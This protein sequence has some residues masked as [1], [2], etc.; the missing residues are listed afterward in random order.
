M[1]M[2]LLRALILLSTTASTAAAQE[3]KGGILSPRGG[4]MVWTL[5]IFG[6]LYF[7][8]RRYAFPPIMAAVEAREKALEA[9]IEGA[10]RDREEAARLLAEQRQQIEAARA[11]AQRFIVEGRAAGEKIRADML[12]QTRQQQ[13]ELLERARRDI[14]A[15][16]ERAI[17]DLRREAV[18]LAIA[19]AGKV[20]E[21]NL[22]E[23]SN[24]RLVESFLA[25][26]ATNS[27]KS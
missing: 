16:K 15:E 7:V 13:Q 14:G 18:D 26:L 17:A 22:D 12:E 24:R 6:L 10:K 19:G 20:I 4:L 1:R 3:A 27:V 9:A 25:S 2:T 21:K 5:L 11:D 8:L 23:Q